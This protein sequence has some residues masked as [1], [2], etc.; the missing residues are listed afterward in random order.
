MAPTLSGSAETVKGVPRL[1]WNYCLP[2]PAL[3]GTFC[4]QP[5]GHS[6]KG[7]MGYF[8]RSDFPPSFLDHL[9]P[10]EYV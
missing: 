2:L 5:T 1:L 6:G 9:T 10:G 3:T 8:R 4:D 7:K